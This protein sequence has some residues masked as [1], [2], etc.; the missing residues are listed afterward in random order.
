MVTKVKK[1]KIIYNIK[2]KGAHPAASYEF[3]VI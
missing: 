1:Y 2:V 3:N